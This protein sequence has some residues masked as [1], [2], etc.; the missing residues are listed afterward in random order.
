LLHGLGFAGALAEIGLPER[1]IPLAL[2]QFNIGV[3]LGQLQ[4]VAAVL[5]VSALARRLAVPWPAWAWRV[6]AYGIGVTAAFWT[7]QRIASFWSAS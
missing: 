4:F 6:P 7:V 1:Q 2:L 5:V 3:E